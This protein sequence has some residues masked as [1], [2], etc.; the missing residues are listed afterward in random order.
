MVWKETKIPVNDRVMTVFDPFPYGN[1][2]QLTR[3]TFSRK[4]FVRPVE[5]DKRRRMSEINMIA[6]IKETFTPRLLDG[7]SD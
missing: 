2:R 3:F 1:E 5:R 6:G 7:G 4:A